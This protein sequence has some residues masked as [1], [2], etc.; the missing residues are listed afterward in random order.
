MPILHSCIILQFS[1]HSLS[2]RK[3]LTLPFFPQVAPAEAHAQH[4]QVER[5]KS[6][7]E[8]QKEQQR[9]AAQLAEERRQ[10]HLR[11]EALQKQQLEQQKEREERL[12]LQREREQQQNREAD[13]KEQQLRQEMLRSD[14]LP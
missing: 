2:D 3:A 9:L 8:Q 14:T 7:Y 13:L 11:Q 10:L 4:A 6:A 1:L 5:V 12:R